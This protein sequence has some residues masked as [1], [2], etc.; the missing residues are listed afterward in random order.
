MELR[1]TLMLTIVGPLLAVA[2]RGGLIRLQFLHEAYEYRTQAQAAGTALS[3]LLDREI[4]LVE[5]HDFFA[6]LAGQLGEY[7]TGRRRHFQQ[8]LELHGSEFRRSVW[9]QLRKIPFGK[10]RSYQQIAT[11][12]G[13]P[14]AA[15]AVGQ[16]VSANPV[17]I[18]L[19]C[20]RVIGADGQLVGFGGGMSLKGHLLR[21]E[22]HT[23][24]ERPRVVAPR[25]F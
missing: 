7:F 18:I 8:P 22:G 10:L 20:H 6:P 4:E 15:R 5:D 24:G 16:A 17:P 11:A 19:P 13:Q 12:M 1:H 3:L 21:L 25:L 23:L 9:R 2:T 14:R